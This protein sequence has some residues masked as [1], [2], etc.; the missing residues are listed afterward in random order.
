MA[1][2]S[3]A[4]AAAV[5]ASAPAASAPPPSA[6]EALARQQGSLRSSLGL[7]CDRDSGEIVVCGRTGP[8]PDRLPLPVPPEP[9]ARRSGEPVDPSDTL[10]LSAE[11]CTAV[12]RNPRCSGGLPI[13]GIAAMIVQTVVKAAIKDEE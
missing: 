1:K 13:L 10:A 9:G 6:D 4:V 2:L 11:T 3:L 7:D 12:G 5:L 8:D